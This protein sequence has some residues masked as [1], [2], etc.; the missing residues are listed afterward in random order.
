MIQR[1]FWLDRIERAWERAPVVWLSGV[2]RVGKTTLAKQIPDAL[3]MNCDLPSTMR[4]L[5]DP[6]R[7][8]AS[9]E[10]PVIVFDEIHR[11]ADPSRLLKIAADEFEHLRILA[12]GSSTLAATVK[13][14]DSLTGR[15]RMVHL[16][17]VLHRELEPFG[18]RSLEKRLLHGGLPEPLL[19][20]DKDPEFFSEWLDSYFSRDVQEL[21]RVAKRRE[22]LLMVQSLLRASGGL[23]EVT[24]LAKHCKL[25]RPTVMGYLEALQVTHV[26]A[27]I[28]PFHGGGRQELLRQPK[29]YGFDTGFVTHS[30]GWD[31]LRA[32]DCGE[33]WEH[34]VLEALVA[35]H[36][37]ERVRFWRDTQRREV[38]FVIPGTRGRCDAVECKWRADAFSPRGLTAF[39]RLHPQGANY[40]VTPEPGGP[41]LRRI[42]DLDVVFC[43]L[44]DLESGDA[45]RL[46]H[47][48]DSA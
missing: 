27:V 46:S 19:A 42:A 34:V 8:L 20:D 26:I 33:L 29:A 48:D 10:A 45:E 30:R 25:S 14:R 6:E 7:F 22:F 38:D 21:F 31:S 13:F 41:Y 43:N 15:K 18:V 1:E 3:V 40:V 16:L 4:R 37:I 47:G 11:L 28:A 2:R 23:L 5:E 35:G 9:V 17:P 24:S 44:S 36:G 12:T 32:E 39:R